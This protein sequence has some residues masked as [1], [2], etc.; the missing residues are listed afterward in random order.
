MFDLS[1]IYISHTI[2]TSDSLPFTISGNGVITVDIKH[3]LRSEKFREQVEALR[4]FDMNR[5]YD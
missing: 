1:L 2:K 5:R 4:N 3:L